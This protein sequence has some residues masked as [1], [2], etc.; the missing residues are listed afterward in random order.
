[1]EFAYGH[2]DRDQLDRRG[3]QRHA[4]PADDGA[5]R[6]LRWA[7]I[8]VSNKMYNGSEYNISVWVMLTPADG[9]NHVINMSLQTTLDGNTSY[10]SMTAIRAS[11]WRRTERG[12]RSV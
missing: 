2:L 10:P 1:M 12:T 5:H 7:Q 6:Q 9:S 8:N 11:P 3:A 4:Q